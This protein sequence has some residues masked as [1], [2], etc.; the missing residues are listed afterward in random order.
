MSLAHP[1]VLAALAA[2]PALLLVGRLRPRQTVVFTNLDVLAAVAP[3][4]S[5]WRR[6]APPALLALAAAALCLGAARPSVARRVPVERATV[7]LVVDAS[8]SMQAQDVRPTRLAA[9]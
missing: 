5:P 4:R 7:I 9:A 2:I 1:A 6:H 8:G 3:G